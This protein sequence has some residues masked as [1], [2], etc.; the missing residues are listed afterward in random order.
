M[1][2]ELTTSAVHGFFKLADDLADTIQ[3][4][5][6]AERGMRDSDGKLQGSHCCGDKTILQCVK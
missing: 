1:G 6:P 2:L 4:L 3:A 5:S